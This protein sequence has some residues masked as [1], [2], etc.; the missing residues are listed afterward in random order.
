MLTCAAI[1]DSAIGSIYPFEHKPLRRGDRIVRV[2][3]RIICFVR[4]YHGDKQAVQLLRQAR[5]ADRLF[6]SKGKYDLIDAVFDL[7][8]I[9]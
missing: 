8:G 7:F 3:R 1:S 2:I 4:V 9:G 6:I 5:L